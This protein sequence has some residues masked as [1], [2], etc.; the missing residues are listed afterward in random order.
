[1]P[2]GTGL[3]RFRNIHP[4]RF[5]DVGIAEQ[6]AVTFAAGL[7]A[8]GLKPIVAIYSS[9]LQRA[10]DQIVHDVCIQDLPVVFA[11]D[12]AGLVGSDGETHQGVFDYSYL[13][14][15]PN[16]H[17]MAPK[18]KWE[19]SDMMK[20]AVALERPAAVRYPRGTAYAGLQEFR[21]PIELGKSELLYS[22]SEVAIFAVG[23]MVKT[24]VEVRALLLEQGLNPTVVNGR[25]IKPIDEESIQEACKTHK[26]IVTLE[27][28]VAS[29]GYGEAV[30][31][32]MKRAG[33]ENDVYLVAIPDRFIE[34]GSV[35]Q[36]KEEIQ[37]DAPCIAKGILER[38]R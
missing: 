26:L 19:L 38:I 29:G 23:S 5:F 33:Y 18:N 12:R 37:M 11:I 6:H 7:A 35:D 13:S 9:F 27:E 20:F 28:N 10:Y 22:G 36:L 21:A 30:V 14:S 17:V 34:H 1:M 24:A 8:G 32:Y 2:D 31:S 4:D 16:M 15:I 3:K 25:F